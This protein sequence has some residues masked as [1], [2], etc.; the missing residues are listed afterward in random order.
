[1][2]FQFEEKHKTWGLTVFLVIVASILV[3]FAVYRFKAFSE[4]VSVGMGIVTP[5]IYGLVFA[6]LLCP[7]YNFTTRNMYSTLRKRAKKPKR[8]LS[9]SK[10]LAT[11]V[12]L[13]VFFIVITGFCWMIIP[14][15]VDSIMHIVSIL[16]DSMNQFIDW[17]DVK[18][19]HYPQI[20]E[21]LENWI[22]RFTENVVKYVEEKMLPSYMEIATSIST[23]VFGVITI[24]KNFFVGIII[25]AYFLNSKDLFAAQSKKLILATCNESRAEEILKGAAF[26][27]KTFGGFINGKIIDSLIV[28]V[29]CFAVMSIF[30]WE[31]P[32]LIS[33]IIGIT[34]IIPFFGPFIG[35]VPS[36]LLILM[37]NPMQCIYFLIFILILQQVD[38]NII[39]PKILGDSTGLSSF[40]VMF[41]ILVGGGLFGFVGMIVGIPIF[42]VFYAYFARTIDRRL[43]S[44]GFSTD[45]R[46][47]TIDKYRV[48]EKKKK[49]KEGPGSGITKG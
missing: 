16:P 36:A 42:A 13:L 41:A 6:Y 4:L 11:F 19:V 47:Y 15:L 20:Q 14:G 35:A 9:V 34:N 10:G 29:I 21:T 39:G 33:C 49:K 3:F 17:I 38:G 37:V 32:L 8:A 23:G 43:D 44:R 1:M 46:D 31:Y 48:K 2:K 22:N 27:N 25:C 12:A 24:L 7:I 26:T 18:T 28:G 45:I 40:W 5:F 30:G